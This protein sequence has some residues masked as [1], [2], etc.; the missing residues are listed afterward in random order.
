[1]IKGALL[2]DAQ[3]SRVARSIA[4]T[5]RRARNEVLSSDGLSLLIKK[6]K[7]RAPKLKYL[8]ISQLQRNL[9]FTKSRNLKNPTQSHLQLIT[10]K[11]NSV[12]VKKF[13][14]I[15]ELSKI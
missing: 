9:Y 11:R 2:S 14:H 13:L 1:M 10:T 15:D 4:L 6:G 8:R 7:K 5:P 12:R 3:P